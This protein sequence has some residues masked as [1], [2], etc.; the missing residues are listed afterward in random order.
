MKL[1]VD[2]DGRVH[3]LLTGRSKYGSFEAW[4]HGHVDARM[5]QVT[6]APEGAHVT[7]LACL[8]AWDRY[9][10]FAMKTGDPPPC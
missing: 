1:V 9:E 6:P 4:P 8:Y 3:R 10:A 2:I 7:C 5:R